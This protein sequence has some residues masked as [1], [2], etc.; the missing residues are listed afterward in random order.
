M[1]WFNKKGEK[2]EEKKQE[3]IRCG[4]MAGADSGSGC[5]SDSDWY[6]GYGSYSDDS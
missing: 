3:K 4:K 5:C 6:S 1:L 2:Q